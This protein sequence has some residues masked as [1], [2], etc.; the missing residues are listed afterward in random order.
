MASNFWDSTHCNNWLVSRRELEHSKQLDLKY[1]T[2]RQLSIISVFFSNLIYRLGK[3]LML[4]QIPIATANIYFKR[5]YLNNALCETDP[6]ILT[7]CCV[8]VAA[9]VDETPV[10]I[11]SVVSEAR[12]MFSE[13]GYRGFPADYTKLAEMEFYLLEDL[14]FD[15]I[16]FHPY[17]TLAAV[18]GREPV[19][20]G[21]FPADPA[22]D[23]LTAAER[24]D[25][26]FGKGSGQPGSDVEDSILQMAWF[27]LNDTY[28]TD[29]SLLY[30]PYLIALAALYLSFSLE[31]KSPRD[32][33]RV[34]GQ[35]VSSLDRMSLSS[36]HA[37]KDDNARPVMDRLITRARAAGYFADFAISLPTMLTIVQEIISLYPLWEDLEGKA[38]S[39]GPQTVDLT[40]DLTSGN[41]ARTKGVDS[42]RESEVIPMIQ[43]MQR[44]RA[45]DLLHPAD[46]GADSAKTAASELGHLTRP[47]A[48]VRVAS[49]SETQITGV[50]RRHPV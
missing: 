34:R 5:F 2:S 1:A 3:K 12:A 6:F 43:R 32:P 41:T 27:I 31:D 39:R 4:R 45:V 15:L 22:L 50:K 18:C 48:A 36:S 33:F 13:F 21:E 42:L 28:R 49:G 7:A 17:R 47:V 44:L 20:A 46:A 19:D 9:K 8:Y 23:T 16:V 30:P 25:K 37:V 11:K 29:L 35:T 40:Q 38:V 14:E 26:L 24:V 10:H